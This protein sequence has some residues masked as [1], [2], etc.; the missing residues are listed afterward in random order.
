MEVIHNQMMPQFLTD[1]S[2]N[3]VLPGEWIQTVP[4]RNAHPSLEF[5]RNKKLPVDPRQNPVRASSLFPVAS[6]SESWREILS[7][8]ESDQ[9]TN[10]LME[11]RT[12]NSGDT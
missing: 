3:P 4:A 1:L 6:F 9:A 7:Q 11:I 8:P 12:E 2:T 10:S 5:W